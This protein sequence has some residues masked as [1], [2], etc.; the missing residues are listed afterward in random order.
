MRSER[1]VAGWRRRSGDIIGL[2]D[3]CERAAQMHS[4]ASCLLCEFGVRHL[5][6]VSAAAKPGTKHELDVKSDRMSH[7]SSQIDGKFLL[8]PGCKRSNPLTLR[9]WLLWVWQFVQ[10]I[11]VKT[12]VFWVLFFVFFV[13]QQRNCGEIRQTC[14]NLFC[15]V[16]NGNEQENL[17][18][19]KICILISAAT[20]K[21]LWA[22]S[23]H[24]VY[25]LTSDKPGGVK[26]QQHLIYVRHTHT[27]TRTKF[28]YSP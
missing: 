23:V 27:G 6:Q 28:C 5:K 18:R 2:G 15:Q 1:L 8:R 10:F 12:L 20:P 21:G 19:K 9:V 13:L 11:K 26:L 3:G 22:N 24:V 4:S 17:C 14:S 25:F 7:V 16:K